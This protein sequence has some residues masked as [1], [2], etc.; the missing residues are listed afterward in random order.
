MATSSSSQLNLRVLCLHGRKQTGNVFEKRLETTI[1]RLRTQSSLSLEWTFLDAPFNEI[2][3]PSEGQKTWWR[4]SEDEHSYAE[5]LQAS[6]SSLSTTLSDVSPHI[7]V[8]FS[9]GCALV[10]E[11]ANAGMLDEAHCPTLVTLI[12]AGGLLPTLFQTP[13]A[14]LLERISTL[15]FAGTKDQ[16]VDVETS[17]TLAN[18]FVNA[19]FVVHQQGHCFPSRASESKMLILFLEKNFALHS[20]KE[21]SVLTAAPLVPSEELLEEL[22]SLQYIFS[23]EEY[24]IVDEITKRISVRVR[25]KEREVSSV[26]R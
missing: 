12:F 19:K 16:A 22:E 18:T 24:T 8:S 26:G 11:A 25:H 4:S 5:D 1:R 23:P 10:A 13:A 20:E 6:L 17:R 21:P 15:H 3:N 7:I 14:R 2:H 9:Q